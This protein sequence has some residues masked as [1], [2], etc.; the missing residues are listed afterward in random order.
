[1]KQ[2]KLTAWAL[3]LLLG[4]QSTG[5]K[6]KDKKGADTTQTAPLPDTTMN[7]MPPPVQ[8]APDTALQTGLRDATK[9]Y[10]GVQATVTNGEVTLSGAVT[11]DRLPNLMAAVSSL[12]PKSINK[13][14][15][16]IK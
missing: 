5:C 16:I 8:I 7:N 9:D 14:Q 10:P 4:V 12:H 2:I 1:M 13:Q 6:S 3:V 11:R 15:L